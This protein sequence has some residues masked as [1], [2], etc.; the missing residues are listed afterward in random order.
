MGV[1]ELFTHV[2][3]NGEAARE[4]HRS[5]CECLGARDA[6]VRIQLERAP[7]YRRQRVLDDVLSREPDAGNQ[8]KRD[9]TMQSAREAGV[10]FHHGGRWIE[11][12]LLRARGGE[13]PSRSVRMVGEKRTG[14]V[15][16]ESGRLGCPISLTAKR[17]PVS[18]SPG[19][20]EEC[21]I[22]QKT[23]HVHASA[24]DIRDERR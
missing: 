11:V 5:R 18:S 21:A 16:G 13:N 9:Q 20:G 2:A 4:C 15:Q 19:Y 23:A 22:E 12:S 17:G 1:V 14:I 6:G 10:S 24:H 7:A 8:G 3:R